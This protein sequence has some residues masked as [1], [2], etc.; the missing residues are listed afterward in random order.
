MVENPGLDLP[1]KDFFTTGEAAAICAVTP[2]A[3]L[4]WVTAGKIEA[5]RTP[6]G[7]Y[8]IPRR[9][10]K[11]LLDGKTRGSE[12]PEPPKP[13]QYC[14]E[15]N[16]NSGNIRDG[17][18]ECIV[19]RSR[20]GRCYEMAKLPNETGHS[21]LFCDQSC[22][23]CKYYELARGTTPNI[24]I[25]TDRPDLVAAIKAQAEKVNCNLNF[26]DCE[27][28]CSMLVESFTPDYIVID[29]SFGSDRSR[30]FAR[31][32]FEDPRIPYSRIILAGHPRDLPKECDQMVFAFIQR[33]LT[34]AA[35][36]GLIT[37]L[38]AGS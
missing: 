20:A 1:K 24:L 35:M 8:R 25:A 13:F 2:N 14:W 12:V 3:V 32:L 21:R 17:C 27:Y 19:Y 7:H 26:T 38:E 4:K 33:P 5:N 36:K 23:E 37:G 10:L 9:A 29:C 28:H 11:R 30:E 18:R 22:A 34:L 6:G 15:F 31:H 16:A